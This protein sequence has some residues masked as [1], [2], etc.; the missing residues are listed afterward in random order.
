[1]LYQCRFRSF[2]HLTAML[3]EW[4]KALPFGLGIPHPIFTGELFALMGGFLLPGWRESSAAVLFGVCSGV[5]TLFA[6]YVEQYG[7]RCAK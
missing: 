2:D 4:V 7:V 1:M 5:L 3:Y 6:I